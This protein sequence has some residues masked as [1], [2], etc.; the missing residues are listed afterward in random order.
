[1]KNSL[2]KIIKYRKFFRLLVLATTIGLLSSCEND[3]PTPEITESY[4]LDVSPE[5]FRFESEGGDFKFEVTSTKKVKTTLGNS[6]SSEVVEVPYKISIS[7][8]WLSQVGDA[9]T[10]RANKNERGAREATITISIPEASIKAKVINI[11]QEA[12]PD[13]WY[14]SPSARGTGSGESIENAADFMDPLFWSKVEENLQTKP[15]EVMFNGGDYYKAYTENGLIFNDFGNENNRLTLRGN[16]EV[17]F[18]LPT[19]TEDKKDVLRFNNCQNIRI[20][21]LHFSG[22][23]R[24]EYTLRITGGNTKNFLIEGCSWIDLPGVIFGATGAHSRTLRIT[25]RECTFKRVGFSGGSHMMYHSYRPSYIGVFDCHFEDCMGDYVRFR[26]GTEFGIVKNSTFIRNSDYPDVVFIAI[27]CFN[28]VTPG[29]ENFGTNFSFTENS[30]QNN[31]STDSTKPIS[32]YHQGYSP[33]AYNYLLN[34]VEGEL[35]T[36]GREV[37][38]IRILKENFGIDV[39]KLRIQENTF[40]TK[41]SNYLTIRTTAAYGAQSLGWEGTAVI[42]DLVKPDKPPFTWETNWQP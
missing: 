15:V 2:I 42:T 4:T 19:G 20:K 26:A 30:F 12:H 1:M 22:D 5:S 24:I 6:T 35:L 13:I 18:T 9:N 16:D 31:A 34:R 10:I 14:V 11:S 40:S 21:N 29:D 28:D 23:G 36:N 32:F 25:Y 41:I 38:K 7:D 37:D 33:Q 39:D 3:V 27:P 17:I 8:N